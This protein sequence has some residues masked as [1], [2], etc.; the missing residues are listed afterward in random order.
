MVEMLERYEVRKLWCNVGRM[1]L[2]KSEIGDLRIMR[3]G[4][5]CHGEENQT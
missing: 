2:G 3:P 1:R 5:I 4:K